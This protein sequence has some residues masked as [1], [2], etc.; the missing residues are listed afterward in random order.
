MREVD[1]GTLEEPYPDGSDPEFRFAY[2]LGV[3]AP[4]AITLYR[5]I[6]A[7][8]DPSRFGVGWW[9][10]HPGTS[11]RILISDHL[12]LCV[13]TIQTNLVEAKLHLLELM[14]VWHTTSEFFVDVIQVRRGRPSFAPPPR[15]RPRDDLPLRLGALHASG[16][17]RALVGAFDCLGAAIVGVA[18]LPT[19][20]LKADLY[21]ALETISGGR[22]NAM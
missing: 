15:I 5:E 7:D 10:P 17:F 2:S 8:L 4:D 21:T 9:H 20:I 16:F 18:A 1:R 6:L 12:L 3:A 22:L 13:L 11:R 19:G 14:D